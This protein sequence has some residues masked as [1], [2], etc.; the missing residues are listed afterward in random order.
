MPWTFA[1]PAIVFPLKKSRYGR[2]LNLPA[3]I[4]AVYRRTCCILPGCTAQRMR[5][6]IL[7]AGF[8]PDCRCV[9]RFC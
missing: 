8:I 5:R 3:L 4:T 9:W 6:I 1:H 7:P 2:W